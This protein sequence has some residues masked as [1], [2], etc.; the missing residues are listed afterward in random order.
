M[1]TAYKKFIK[2]IIWLSLIIFI[3]R[4]LIGITTVFEL[5][6]DKQ[7]FQ[8]SYTFFGYCG[9]SVGISFLLSAIY[10]R[11]LWRYLNFYK[12]PVLSKHFTG[13][14]V[15]AY[16]NKERSAELTIRQTFLSVYVS[17]KTSESWSNSLYSELLEH[18]G[19]YKLFYTYVNEPKAELFER[20]N[21]HYGSVELTVESSNHLYGNYYT[22]RK[23]NGSM[24]FLSVKD[25]NK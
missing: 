1:K 23:T 13:T 6:E 11:W 21:I 24:N 18:N 3:I 10:E 16:D 5:I 19:T 4:L 20:S 8:L 9:E 22:N 25:N 15:S 14:F 7:M 2:I 17:M 12:V